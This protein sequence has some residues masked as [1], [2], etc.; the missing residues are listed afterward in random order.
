MV[1]GGLPIGSTNDFNPSSSLFDATP[2]FADEIFMVSAAKTSVQR[3][4]A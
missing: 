3:P 4:T 2:L 1:L